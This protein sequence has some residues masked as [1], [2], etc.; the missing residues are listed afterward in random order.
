MKIENPIREGVAEIRRIINAYI[1]LI[2]LKSVKKG[3]EIGSRITYSVLIIVLIII[4]C[5]FLSIALALYLGQLLGSYPLGFLIVGAL[6]ILIMLLMRI[7][8]ER[9]ILCLLNFFIKIMTKK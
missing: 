8:K 3:A 4:G 5:S 2:K 1:E 9:A 6:P 7:F